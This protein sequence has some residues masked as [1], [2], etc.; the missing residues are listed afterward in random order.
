MFKN[1]RWLLLLIPAVILIFLLVTCVSKRENESVDGDT[2]V[3]KNE[4]VVDADSYEDTYHGEADL[5]GVWEDIYDKESTLTFDESGR[6]QRFYNGLYSGTYEVKDGHVVLRD[7]YGTETWYRFVANENGLFT[8]LK[9]DDDSLGRTF[10]R[11][12]EEPAE[13]P[14]DPNGNTIEVWRLRL[15]MDTVREI[16]LKCPWE[17]KTDSIKSVKVTDS[18]IILTSSNGTE[19][20]WEYTIESALGDEE[21]HLASIIINGSPYLMRITERG[22]GAVDGYTVKIYDDQSTLLEMQSNNYV[23]MSE[24]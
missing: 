7:E 22:A 24:D 4:M 21:G 18:L 14:T 16:L 13:Q 15:Y 2:S 19:T 5:L 3:W 9:Q 8:W 10:K 11:V 23:S 1:K 6:F 17:S 12:S 20:Q